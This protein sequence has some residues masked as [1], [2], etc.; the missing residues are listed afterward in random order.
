MFLFLLLFI[1]FHFDYFRMFLINYS[2]IQ[3]TTINVKFLFV[4]VVAYICFAFVCLGSCINTLSIK[5]TIHF[6]IF[7]IFFFIRSLFLLWLLAVSTYILKKYSVLSKND[8]KL[9]KPGKWLLRLERFKLH[10]RVFFG[11]RKS[12]LLNWFIDVMTNFGDK[13]FWK[14][15][16]KK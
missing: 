10:C 4:S 2:R 7:F 1:F 9:V 16:T 15:L 5:Y 3:T 8:E 14:I 12:I 13:S 11:Q 6:F